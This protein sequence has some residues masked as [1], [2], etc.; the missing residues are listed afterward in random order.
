MF[1]SRM[2]CVVRCSLLLLAVAI[3]VGCPG[4]PAIPS[5]SQFQ[6]NGGAAT[7]SSV[8]VTLNS[9]VSG[10]PTE[11]IASESLT[12]V[13]AT[14][15]TYS[16]SV[17]F[18][19][20]SGDGLKT[21]Y[22]QVRNGA[23]ESAAM[24]DTISLQET[25]VT[26]LLP[27]DV[28]LTMTRVPGATYSM[29]RNDS[30][31]DS[32]DSE[33]PQ[34]SVSVPGFWMAKYEITKRQWQAVMNTTPWSG[35]GY[36]LNN[37]DSPAVFVSWDNAKA[38]ITALNTWTGDAFRLPS[39]AEWEFACRAGTTTRFYWGDDGTYYD[40]DAYTWWI[41]TAWD[42]NEAYAHVVGQLLPNAL[43]LYDMSGNAFEWCEDDWHADYTGAVANGSAWV[44]TVPSTDKVVRS[45]SWYS[46]GN[47]CRSASRNFYA[48]D[49]T[50]Y[51]IG[52]RI[53]WS[54]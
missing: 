53:A 47:E 42:A 9:T 38:F 18:E 19:L 10:S 32:F 4:T 3:G 20:S 44:G 36:V 8:T 45:G 39:E 37:L 1:G 25:E 6:I 5:V 35:N 54:Q 31:Q 17:A 7:S 50:S 51:L 48:N 16:T 52:F 11:Y 12:F 29:G 34:H 27:G 46:P 30:E 21:V 24:S 33:S 43:G 40:G 26:I 15:Q 49:F 23:G 13:G 41:Y 14:W 2:S 28:P 22:F